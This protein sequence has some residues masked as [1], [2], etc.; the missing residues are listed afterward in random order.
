[1]SNMDE[2]DQLDPTINRH[3]S[4][5]RTEIESQ[6]TSAE[7]QELRRAH[8][9]LRFENEHY[10]RSHPEV[11]QMISLAIQHILEVKPEES[12]IEQAYVQF[13]S[14]EDLKE[15]VNKSVNNLS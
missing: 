1:M 7:E 10:L 6:L 12:Q 14:R 3:E 13:L 11:L 15:L 5:K 9:N 2:Q 8:R 4:R